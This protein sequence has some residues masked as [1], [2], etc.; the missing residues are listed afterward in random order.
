MKRDVTVSYRVH[1]LI[2]SG[3][4]YTCVCVC[5]SVC[6]P[7][8][9]EYGEIITF[10]VNVFFSLDGVLRCWCQSG[11]LRRLFLIEGCGLLL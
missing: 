9:R 2:L 6:V 4:M 8:H 5:V 7:V 1:V 11:V 3:S 10:S